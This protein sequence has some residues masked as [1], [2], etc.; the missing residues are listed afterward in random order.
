M[1]I[2]RAAVALEKKAHIVINDVSTSIKPLYDEIAQSSVY[3]KDIFLTSGEALDYISDSAMVVVVDTNKPQMTE[4]PELLKRSKTIAVLDH[5]RQSSTVIDNAVLSYIEP[6]SSSTCEM[7][8][9]YCSI[10]WMIS[11]CRPLR[12]TAVCRNHDRY[13][14]FH[15]P[16][17]CPYI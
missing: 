13:E 1:G 3:G 15:E 11:R 2:Y 17:R 6:Y 5:H 8:Q 10:L 14:E 4:C 7:V 12:Q 16:Y 9:K